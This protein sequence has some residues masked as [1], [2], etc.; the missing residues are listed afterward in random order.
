MKALL[1]TLFSLVLLNFFGLVQYTYIIYAINAYFIANFI[2]SVWIRRKVKTPFDF[3]LSVVLVGLILSGISSSYY[4][5]SNPLYVYFAYQFILALYFYIILVNKDTQVKHVEKALTYLS[6]AL[7]VFYIVQYIAFQRG[8]VLTDMFADGYDAE[9]GDLVRF[10]AVGSALAAW[11]YFY[12]LNG[13][14]VSQ[15]KSFLK[16]LLLVLGLAV[17]LLMSFRTMV[18]GLMLCT[19]VMVIKVNGLKSGLFKYLFLLFVAIVVAYNVPTVQKKID[20]MIEKQQGD[21]TF[22]NDDYIRW[23]NFYYHLDENTKDDV[24]YYLGVGLNADK[25]SSLCIKED[26]LME[27]HLS[28]VDWG[29]IGLSWQVGLLTVLG[30]LLYS[31]KVIKFRFEPEQVCIS[32]FF[33][34]LVLI[35]ITTLEF[36]RTGNFVVQALVL[37]LATYYIK[38]QNKNKIINHEKIN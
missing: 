6:L 29:L 3:A 12:G 37:Y 25:N 13:V 18:A 15:K 7:C 5:N 14:L 10:R 27:Q 28:W 35:S 34:Y 9:A 16:V 21:Q 30:M 26:N 1:I 24:E 32:V 23:I 4:E 38:K 36:A 19:L 20:Y 2:Y 8:I 33:L 31:F 11:A 22:A 17:I